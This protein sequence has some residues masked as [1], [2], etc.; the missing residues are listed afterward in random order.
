MA[1]HSIIGTDGRGSCRFRWAH[2]VGVALILGGMCMTLV[3]RW[4]EMDKGAK[5]WAVALILLASLPS[6]AAFIRVEAEFT[7]GTMEVLWGWFIIN[8]WQVRRPLA[9]S[10]GFP[11]Y[12][13][14]VFEAPTSMCIGC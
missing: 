10:L 9:F 11:V 7:H 13:S 8:C 2:Y 12:F 3:P 6:V 14:F 4:S 1:T 5:E